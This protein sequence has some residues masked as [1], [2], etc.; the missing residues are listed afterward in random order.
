[1]VISINI[2]TKT[3]NGDTYDEVAINKYP[4]VI[5]DND[6]ENLDEWLN[7][8]MM[9]NDFILILKHH[10]KNETTFNNSKLYIRAL[11][12]EM[13]DNEQKIDKIIK[14]SEKI[15]LDVWMN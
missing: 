4:I 3:K 2:L 5:I 11:I 9:S 8:F 12:E 1:M 13:T 7:E 15:E 6:A 10:I 14:I